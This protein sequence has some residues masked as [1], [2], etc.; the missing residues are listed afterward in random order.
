[1]DVVDTEVAFG[2][3][4]VSGVVCDGPSHFG[5]TVGD[6]GPERDSCSVGVSTR[7]APPRTLTLARAP[8]SRGGE[9]DGGGGEESLGEGTETDDCD[10]F[11]EPAVA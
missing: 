10:K 7:S 9:L 8:V 6:N 11:E 3:W 4:M 5:G 1:M 2:E